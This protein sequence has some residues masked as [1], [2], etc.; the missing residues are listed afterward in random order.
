[1]A[2]QTPPTGLAAKPE[3]GPVIETSTTAF[4]LAAQVEE[5]LICSGQGDPLYV[6][7]CPEAPA[8]VA[9]LQTVAQQAAFLGQ[10][11]P[12]GNFD[13][14]EI[15]LANSRA[16]AQAK[17]DRMIFVRVSTS[18]EN[19]QPKS[20]ER[21]LAGKLATGAIAAGMLGCGIRLPDST[22]LSYSFNESYPR[23]HLDQVLHQLAETVT[24]LAG[25]GLA[26]RRLIWTF[27]QGRNLP[28]PATGRRF[29]GCGHPAQY[30]CGGKCGSVG[31]RI[32]TRSPPAVDSGRPPEN[33]NRTF[34]FSTLQ[35][36]SIL[37][38]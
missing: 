13:R 31:R 25:H 9:L 35:F 26:P 24:L 15:Q 19:P 29:A 23:E 1:M 6:W 36:A 18:A 5:T 20:H 32:F 14:L 22:C 4:H 12:L 7:Q 28:D 33:S 27:D 16:V 10:L 8:R 34:Y 37:T 21:H 11:M 38:G 30:R 17:A 3:P 2:A